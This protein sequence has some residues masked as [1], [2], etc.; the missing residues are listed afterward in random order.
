MS[1]LSLII[2][3]E[4]LTRVRKKSFIIATLLAPIGI[5]IYL[6]VIIGLS[7]YQS[8][9][10]LKVVIMDEAGMVGQL[11]DA[12]G[13]RFIPAGGK[14]LKQLKTEVTDQKIDG[15][16]RIP[17]L[18][19][20]QKKEHT[21]FY[22]SNEKLAPEK[23]G[24]IEKKVGEKIRDFK[25]DSLHLSRS[26]L[27]MLDTD[28]SIDPESISGEDNGDNKYTA[29]VGLVVGGIM[30]FLM[31]FMVMLYG[32]MVMRSVMEEKTSRIVEVMM[33]SV[34]PFDLRMGKIIGTGAVGLTQMVAWVLLSGAVTFIIP[35]IM[36]VDPAQM[37]SMSTPPPGM[38]PD[39][40]QGDAVRIFAELGKQNWPLIIGS[41][42]IFFLGGYF[43][44]ASM[45]AA[46]GS[47]MGDD[48]GEG[49]SLTLPVV[50]PIVLAFYFVSM[51]G[52]RNPDSN[53]MIF[54]SLFPLFSP[55]AMPFR[56]AFNPP[57]WQVALS[58]ILVVATAIFFVW[59]AG[60]IYRVG[61][62]LYGKKGSL[63]EISKWLFYKG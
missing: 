61:I 56:M 44:Y 34:R 14:S 32:Q 63:K 2:R 39:Q 9:D 10:E 29:G 8:G 33:S 1:K 19:T 23:S 54:A 47:A 30:T 27:E 38:D 53:L 31:F 59:M 5:L 11:P 6:L 40:M 18:G 55:I 58:L 41:F 51:A 22:Y 7:T 25:I 48:M 4:Y 13:V 42:I 49:Q 16:L 15:V 12:K 37:Q 43:I 50:I 3:R 36:N 20:F 52:L 60:R 45:F 57:W 24:I 17:R 35:L 26:S 21:V 28:I 46:I 62:L